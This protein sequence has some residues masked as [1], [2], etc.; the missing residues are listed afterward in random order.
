ANQRFRIWLTVKPNDQVTAYL[1]LE[2][3]HIMWGEDYEF[4]KTY[5]VG[6]D[7]VGMETRRGYIAYQK[8]DL[9]TFKIGIQDWSDSFG[10]TLASGD[11]DFDLGGVSFAR[12]L[13][14]SKD[15][16]L[17]VGVFQLWEGN[18]RSASDDSVLLTADLRE[19]SLENIGTFNLSFYQL[20]D[21]G[22]YSYGA[23][24]GPA[25]AYKYSKDVWVGVNWNGQIGTI[26]VTAFFIYNK[27]GTHN[28]DWDHV[29]NAFKLAASHNLGESKLSLHLLSSTGNDDLTDPD[30]SNEFRTIAQSERDNY[31]MMG[32]W[33]Y[34][35]IAAARGPSDVQ[36]LGVS[37]QNRGLG[38]T[39]LEAKLEFPIK[40]KLSGYLACGVLKATEE[41]A[42]GEDSL[43]TEVV[44]EVTLDLSGGL[45]LDVGAGYFL[46]GD[47]YQVNPT[48]S[49]DDLHEFYI[50]TQLEF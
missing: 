40:E 48:D 13:S 49:P 1:Q 11:H 39:A 8:D 21:R 41:N 9:G 20:S 10:D 24:G 33:S 23:F 46:T 45:K 34:L 27:G 30:D 5:T 50:R 3:G 36:D 18:G 28:P 32:Y 15:A 16:E 12:K 43:G 42:L 22:D 44:G 37:L 38:L 14:F 4:P 29:G 26:P 7:Q 47:F 17:L 35:G 31:G 19:I 25:A 2:M 6:G